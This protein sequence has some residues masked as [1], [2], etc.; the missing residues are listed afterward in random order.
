MLLTQL[1]QTATYRDDKSECKANTSRPHPVPD[2]LSGALIEGI[3]CQAQSV[4]QVDTKCG[5]LRS[6]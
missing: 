6:S 2:R 5:R 4:E 1:A 3:Y